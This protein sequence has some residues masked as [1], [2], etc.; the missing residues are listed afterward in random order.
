MVGV[1]LTV[2]TGKLC[3]G[4]QNTL[5]VKLTVQPELNAEL[6]PVILTASLESAGYLL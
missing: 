5:T 2:A 1:P 3:C 6:Q 4:M